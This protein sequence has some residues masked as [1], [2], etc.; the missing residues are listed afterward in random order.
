[1]KLFDPDPKLRWLFCMTHPDDEISICAWIHR[2]RQAGAHVSMCWTH[3]APHREHEARGVAKLLGVTEDNLTFLN[4]PDGGVCNH[5][6]ELLPTMRRVVT[7]A[8][9]DRVVCGAF[10]QGHLDHDSTN[11]LVNRA[12]A[13][14]VLE[15]PLYHAYHTRLQNMNCF[16]QGR[17]GEVLHLAPDEARFK[18]RVARQ[19]PSQNI[20]T[21]LLWHE[22]WQAARLRPARLSTRECMR[23]QTH[24]DFTVPNL[25]PKVAAKVVKTPAW[26]RWR[27]AVQAAETA[28]QP[29][30]T[31]TAKPDLVDTDSS[32][33][34]P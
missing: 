2:L 18:R 27:A 26:M 6:A 33:S 23:L 1:M 9:P 22:V 3:T 32:A 16:A 12:W 8:R 29:H 7:K 17:C 30:P 15:V 20:W 5:L 13:G 14:P 11:W 19:Y 34:T 4:A 28:V 31:G 10:E 25:P 21:V 24:N